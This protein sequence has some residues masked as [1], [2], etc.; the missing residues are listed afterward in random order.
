MD[1]RNFSNLNPRVA[2]ELHILMVEN[3]SYKY[4]FITLVNDLYINSPEFKQF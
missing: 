4:L 3:D 2:L 1:D